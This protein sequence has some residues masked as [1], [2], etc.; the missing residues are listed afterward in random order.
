MTIDDALA[1]A[2]GSYQRNLILGRET[3]SGSSL[4]GKAAKYGLHYARSRRAL[5]ERLEDNDIG[6]LTIGERGKIEFV[7]GDPPDGWERRRV[8]V[9]YAYVCPKPTLLDTFIQAVFEENEG[10]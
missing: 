2:R 8:A 6:Y 4:K 3:W 7:L 10:K 5:L 1:Q 9:G